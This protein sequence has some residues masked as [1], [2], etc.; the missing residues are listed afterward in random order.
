MR[1]EL[2]PSGSEREWCDPEVLR[3]L[4]RASLAVLRKEIEAADQ[5][6]LAAFLPRW[7]GVD[8]HPAGGAGR[9]PP[10]RGARAAAGPGAAR[11]RLGARRPAAPLRRLLADV[12]GPAVRQRRGRVGRRRRARAQLGPRGALLPRR[13]RGHRAAAQQVRAAGHARA[14]RCCASAWPQAPCFFTDLLAE[15]PISPEQIQEALWDLV[16][17]GEVTNDA[18]APLRAPRLTLARAQR[19]RDRTPRPAGASARAAAARRRRS[20][21]AGR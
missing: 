7:Q 1:G 14:R 13:R 11:R 2:R 16:W 18:W 8:R 6:A 15:L 10:A 20:R 19:A 21:A 5:R 9:R 17:A 4:R 12:A 3:R